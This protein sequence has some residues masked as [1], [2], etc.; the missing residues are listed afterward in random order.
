[1]IL[2]AAAWL[3]WHVP[4]LNSLPDERTLDPVRPY[5]EIILVILLPTAVGYGLIGL[6]RLL[7][8]AGARWDRSRVAAPEPIERLEGTLRRLR[9]E[10]ESLETRRDL[11]NKNARVRALRGAYVDVLAVACQR[12]EVRP[13]LDAGPSRGLYTDQAEIYRVEAALRQRGLNV[14]EPA[15]H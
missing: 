14:R 15:A 11:P 7:R 3:A 6:V 1:M 10:L 5:V 9:A 4:D 12:L 8:W 2:L 13:P